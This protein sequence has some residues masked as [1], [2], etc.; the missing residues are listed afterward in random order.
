MTRQPS[1]FPRKALTASLAAAFDRFWK[2]YPRRSPNPRAMAEAAFMAA[3]KAG[4]DPEQLVAAAGAYA[5]LVAEKRTEEQFIAH[6][7]TFLREHRYLDYAQEPEA[8]EPGPAAAA[9]DHPLWSRLQAHMDRATFLAWI[10]R[11][12][13]EDET[14]LVVTLKAPSRFI[15]Q[16]IGAEFR[17]T[18]ERALGKHVMVLGK[19]KE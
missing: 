4:A 13:L 3:V 8:S 14:D 2:A 15:A 16:H 11:C 6:A 19:G 18:L 17:P 12:E 1:M 9:P 5:A 7:S 10:G